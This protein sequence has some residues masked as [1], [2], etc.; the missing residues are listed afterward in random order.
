ML[1]LVLPVALGLTLAAAPDKAVLVVVPLCDGAA[2]ACGNGAL[3]DPKSLDGNLYWGAM[4]G[5]ERFLAKAKGFRV[6]TR[7]DAPDAK[8]RPALLRETVIAHANVTL[9][10]QA[11]DGT[12][13]DDALTAFL[14]ATRAGK[15]DLVVWAGHDR[16]MDVAAPTMTRVEKAAPVAVLACESAKY[17]GP[18]LDDIG[19]KPLALTRTF[20]A[21]EAY[22]LEAL[23]RTI[24]QHGLD[25]ART[26]EA[27]IGAYAKYQRISPKAAGTVF[28]KLE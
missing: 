12:R 10:L 27:L 15:H 13:I 28:T 7:T 14:D 16:L 8:G 6:V 20:M 19:A 2:L 1:A 11:W 24:A 3:G 17:F 21:P 23:A 22:L 25:R 4:Y 18:V 9:T 26:R 5:A